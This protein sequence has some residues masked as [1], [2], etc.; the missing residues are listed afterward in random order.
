MCFATPVMTRQLCLHFQ[1]FN[2]TLGGACAQL[3]A[4]SQGLERTA[5]DMNTDQQTGHFSLTFHTYNVPFP[6]PAATCWPSG[7]MQAVH[8]MV[9][10]LKWG[11]LKLCRTSKVC[12]STVLSMLSFP[13]VSTIPAP[14]QNRTWMLQLPSATSCIPNQLLWRGHC[15]A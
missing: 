2:D 3:H 1:E 7:D 12:G 11:A 14:Q 4:C 5:A 10:T 13:H 8:Q 6:E 9:P 15:D